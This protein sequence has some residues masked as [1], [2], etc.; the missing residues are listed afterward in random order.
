M[1]V[2][3]GLLSKYSP[4]SLAVLIALSFSTGSLQ[5]QSA[6]ASSSAHS[7]R[8]AG[9]PEE[10]VVTPF[11]YFH[12]SCVLSLAPG[13]RQLPDGR[14]QHAN[15]GLDAKAPACIYPRYSR[16]GVP[17]N[18]GARTSTPQEPMVSGW[19]ETA[20]IA[21][22]SPVQSYGGLAATWT[23]PPPPKADDGQWL[24][25]FPGLEDLFDVQSILQPVLQWTAGQWAVANWN[26]CLANIAVRSALVNVK[27]GDQIFGSISSDCPAGTLTCPTWNVFSLDRRS[28]QSTILAHT[29]SNGQSFNW[30]FGGTLE[31]YYVVSCDDFPRGQSSFSVIVF[32]EYL[33]PVANPIWSLAM[34]LP[35]YLDPD[36]NYGVQ[37][38]PYQI[39]LNY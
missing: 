29:P 26:C 5:A 34:P 35:G 25:F 19:L 13:D 11:G 15:G 38:K 18:A 37:S 30:A 31:P 6:N 33:R 10:Y 12:P 9:V 27:P 2:F 4:V 21:T 3:P 39:T 24:F 16:S 28:K 1:R 20:Y 23:V 32:D 17:V 7:R 36:C 14:V 8:P 22:W